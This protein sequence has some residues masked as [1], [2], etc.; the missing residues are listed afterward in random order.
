MKNKENIVHT[1]AIKKKYSKVEQEIKRNLTEVVLMSELGS[2]EN[3]S[4]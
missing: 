3:I 1:E 4:R 2:S